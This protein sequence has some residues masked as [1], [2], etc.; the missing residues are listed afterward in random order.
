MRLG[1]K[2]AMQIFL[3]K[4]SHPRYDPETQILAFF[5]KVG[6]NG[7]NWYQFSLLGGTLELRLLY[8][9]FLVYKNKFQKYFLRFLKCLFIGDLEIG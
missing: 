9:I 6:K 3:E 4:Y 2:L 1:K 8:T 7:Q 5:P